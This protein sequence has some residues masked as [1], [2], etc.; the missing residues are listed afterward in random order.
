MTG[1]TKIFEP[2]N[3]SS[4]APMTGTE[5]QQAFSESARSTFVNYLARA[6]HPQAELYSPAESSHL[7]GNNPTEEMKAM[8]KKVLDVAMTI[9]DCKFWIESTK[10]TPKQTA[11]KIYQ[12]FF[13]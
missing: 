1:I 12:K 6:L 7:F 13:K 5:K 11:G 3:M 10:E 8:L 2:V 9:D 4:A